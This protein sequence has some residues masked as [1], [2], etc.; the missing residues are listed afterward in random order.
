MQEIES[1]RLQPDEEEPLRQE[2]DRLANAETLA[3]LAQE[4][5]VLLDEG[6]DDVPALSDGLGQVVE[7][8]TALARIDKTLAQYAATVRDMDE[9]LADL[10][11]NLRD[12]VDQIEYN[13]RRLEQVDDRLD[14][15]QNLK[16]KYGATIQAVMAFGGCEKQARVD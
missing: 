9:E 13:P 1:A 12:Y 8:L 5:L 7:K 11:R 16:R 15:I 4:S 14:L 3:A 2:R 10:I 6:S